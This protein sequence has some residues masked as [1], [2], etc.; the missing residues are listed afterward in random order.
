MNL[1]LLY[2]VPWQHGLRLGVGGFTTP[3]GHLSYCH[4]LVFKCSSAIMN[5]E[6]S[7][8][9][10]STRNKRSA[11]SAVDNYATEESDDELPRPLPKR[12][13]TKATPKESGSKTVKRGKVGKLSKLP[14][15]PLDI[16]FEVAILPITVASEPEILLPRYFPFSILW[17]SCSW[18]EQ[19]S[20][21]ALFSCVGLQDLFG[22]SPSLL[23]KAC[24]SVP[25][26]CQNPNMP[27]SRS[28]RFVRRVTPTVVLSGFNHGSISQVCYKSRGTDVIWVWHR[29]FCKKCLKQLF[30]AYPF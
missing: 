2:H 11:T 9:R 20:A 14:D 3:L 15:M 28:T 16:L 18:P 19:Q 26:T 6:P 24:P 1:S 25:M 4:Q 29:R 21:S 22:L 7:V 23:S 8:P 5:P 13:K 17:I 12:S 10:P 30:V 27:V